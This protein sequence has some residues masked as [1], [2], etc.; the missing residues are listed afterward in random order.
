MTQPHIPTVEDLIMHF[1]S[2]ETIGG[3]SA[4]ENGTITVSKEELVG[5]LELLF[6][7]IAELKRGKDFD[8]LL[9][10]VVK[11]RGALFGRD[12]MAFILM[13]ETGKWGAF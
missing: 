9:F 10:E 2:Q 11:K 12:F 5:F 4:E 3:S 6:N 7:F 13:A 8:D 1:S